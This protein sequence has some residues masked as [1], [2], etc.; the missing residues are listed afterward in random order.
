MAMITLTNSRVGLCDTCGICA[1]RRDIIQI[2]NEGDRAQLEA[3]VRGVVTSV[4]RDVEM[5][6]INGL[7]TRSEKAM[8]PIG[9]SARHR[10]VCHEDL[11]NLFVP[12]NTITHDL[13]LSM[14]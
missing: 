4:L 14:P 2:T 5:Y 8:V 13:H 10:H 7:P 1:E 6:G 12:G 3:R 9:V 11:Q